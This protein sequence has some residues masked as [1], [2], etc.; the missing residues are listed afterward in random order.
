VIPL[1]LRYPLLLILSGFC[2]AG[3]AHATEAPHQPLAELSLRD[4]TVLGV[5]EGVTEFLPI[6]STGHLIVASELLGLESEKPLADKAGQPLWYKK[7]TP[8]RPEGVPLTLKLAA[9]TYTVIIQVGAIAAVVILY[10]RQLLSMALGL[11]GRSD[12]GLRLLRNVVL[13]TLPAAVI[14]LLTHEWIDEKLFSWQAVVAAQVVGA[15]LM[16]WAERWRHANS[17]VGSS[18]NDPSDLTP[19]KSIGIGFAQCLALWPGT[20]RSM[21]TIVGGYLTGLN[22]VKAAE[23]SFLVGLPTLTGAAFLK[24]VKTGPAM[25]EVFGWG[26]MLFGCLV[27]AISAAI[28]VRFL[29]TFLSRH[30]L[31]L[32]AWYRLIVA[33][34]L[35]AFFLL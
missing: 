5:I 1:W 30:G 12:R 7:P 27:A 25:V 28:A 22:P 13:A 14:G 33:V 20:S 8:D 11:L 10:W 17:G 19:R 24:A 16:F 15:L 4:A 9:D 32:F 35:T 31:A 26:N 29:V 2:A 6:S 23:F 34:V 3:A 21:V 18:R